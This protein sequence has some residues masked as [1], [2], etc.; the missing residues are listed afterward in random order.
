MP[1]KK[2]I[3]AR[4]GKYV[5]AWPASG[6]S[7]MSPTGPAKIAAPISISFKLSDCRLPGAIVLCQH[8]NCRDLYKFRRLKLSDQRKLDPSFLPVDCHTQ[9]RQHKKEQHQANYVK[10]RSSI[11]DPPIIR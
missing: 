11:D 1:D 5:I 6:S 2:N 8:Q 4:I 3:A 7:I 10:N 9:R